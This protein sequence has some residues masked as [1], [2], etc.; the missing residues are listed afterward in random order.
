[1]MFDIT[2]QMNALLGVIIALD[3]R[4]HLGPCPAV[5]LVMALEISP[6]QWE[7]VRAVG[8]D[9][10]LIETT[11]RAN[12]EPLPPTEMVGLTK[13]GLEFARKAGTILGD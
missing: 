1:M 8:V 11:L 3:K 10:E 4:S 9:L 5:L 6:E 12:A 2:A 7:A 13:R